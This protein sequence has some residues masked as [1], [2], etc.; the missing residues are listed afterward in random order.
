MAG[1]EWTDPSPGLGA[2]AAMLG[3]A[4]CGNP[5][6]DVLE[7]SAKLGSLEGV[8]LRKKLC[9]PHAIQAMTDAVGV[10]ALDEAAD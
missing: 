7:I 6:A 10:A 5:N 9:L 1:A 3:C 4:E 2:I 8:L